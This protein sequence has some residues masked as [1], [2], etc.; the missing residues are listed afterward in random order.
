MNT[1]KQIQSSTTIVNENQCIAYESDE[2][3]E[4]DNSISPQLSSI[5]SEGASVQSD[6]SVVAPSK[7]DA[8][9]QVHIIYHSKKCN[10]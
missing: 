6:Y 3:D 2:S 8:S 5:S 9:S 4:S 10:F 7:S 1:K